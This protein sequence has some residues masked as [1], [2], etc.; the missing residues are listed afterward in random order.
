MITTG[1]ESTIKAIYDNWLNGN[2]KYAARIIKTLPKLD[3][4][5]LLIYYKEVIPELRGCTKS[6]VLFEFFIMNAL[7]GMFD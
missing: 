3:V 6:K 5:K 2:K 4:A 7:D 1:E